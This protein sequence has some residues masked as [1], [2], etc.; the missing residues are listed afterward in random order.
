MYMSYMY[1]IFFLKTF[2]FSFLKQVFISLCFNHIWPD[3]KQ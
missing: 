2:S 1:D 3:A